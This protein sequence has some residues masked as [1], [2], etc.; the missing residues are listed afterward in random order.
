MRRLARPAWLGTLRRTR[1]LSESFGSD[2]GTPLDRYYI[3]RFLWQ[4]RA[5]IRGVAI[6]VKDSHYV[7][8]FG[9][10]LNRVE[11][12]DIEASNPAATIVA[13]LAC[14][15]SIASDQFDCFVLTQ[16]LQFIYDLP[17]AV[18]HVERILRP[19]GVLLATLPAVGRIEP[20]AAFRGGGKR[21]VDEDYWRF[22]QA[23]ARTLFAGAF[24]PGQVEVSSYGNV[25]T[26]IAFL[27]AMA[28]EELSKREMDELDPSFPVTIGVRAVK[29]EPSG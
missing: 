1:P 11:V 12:L 14:A 6:E 3:A 17:A 24:G 18:R 27:I 28:G 2:R 20:D 16:T 19:G 25:L 29:S 22:T 26:A 5:D 7:H 23:S 15:N 21:G 9:S 4:H 13:D 8:R 10:Q